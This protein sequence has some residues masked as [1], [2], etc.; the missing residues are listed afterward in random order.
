MVTQKKV[1]IITPYTFEFEAKTNGQEFKRPSLT[2]PDMAM[3]LAEILRRFAVGQPIDGIKAEIYNDDEEIPNVK[4]MDLTEIDELVQHYK[5]KIQQAREQLAKVKEINERTA[6]AF[7]THE[8]EEK[9]PNPKTMTKKTAKQ[10][11][12]FGEAGESTNT[13]D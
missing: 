6:E 3:P 10:T 7:V 4:E 13:L 9:K 5:D 1:I 2:I 12:L 11:E 8:A